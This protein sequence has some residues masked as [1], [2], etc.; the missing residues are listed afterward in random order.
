MVRYDLRIQL[1]QQR[2]DKMDQVLDDW[3]DTHE[4]PTAAELGMPSSLSA[5]K[6]SKPAPARHKHH[7]H[8]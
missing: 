7:K 2:E 8:A 4:M 1:W 5:P 6:I 3:Q